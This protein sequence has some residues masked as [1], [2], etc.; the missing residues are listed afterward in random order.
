MQL[1]EFSGERRRTGELKDTEDAARAAKK[2]EQELEA[3][4]RE[5]KQITD[6]VTTAEEKY[7][8][9]LERAGVLLD[10]NVLGVDQY[11]RYVRALDEELLQSK[12]ALEEW[13][14][15]FSLVG[16]AEKTYG[17][18][19]GIA[20]KKKELDDW[21]RFFATIQLAAA[22]AAEWMD[23]AFTDALFDMKNALA[24]FGDFAVGVFR[25]IANAM[26]GQFITGPLLQSL[27]LK[28]PEHRATGGPV[29]AG[30]PYIVGER[31]PE[32]FVPQTS[33]TI[34]PSAAGAG[35]VTLNYAP[36]IQAIDTRSG[37]EFLAGHSRTI[38]AILDRENGRRY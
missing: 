4:R 12:R 23:E 15:T 35:G 27:N 13:N 26:V 7:N 3:L 21:E 11:R 14:L 25:Q 33:G 17:K 16:S 37:L 2:A 30:H 22:E 34:I 29:L 31:R 9:A 20:P 18:R 38:V 8:K 19:K 6:E 1:P 5:A 10:K 24:I 28:L 36:V 32:I